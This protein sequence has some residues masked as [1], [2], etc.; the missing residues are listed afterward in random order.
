MYMSGY[1]D[2][3]LGGRLLEPDIPFLQKPFTLSS[4]VH[5]IRE[6]LDQ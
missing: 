4:L 5:R 1:A 3:A 2:E 6:V